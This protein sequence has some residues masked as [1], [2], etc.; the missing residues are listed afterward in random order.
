MA[1][2][3]CDIIIDEF[4]QIAAEGPRE[5]DFN[6]TREYLLKEWDNSLELNGSWM[7]YISTLTMYGTDY[8][9]DYRNE[10]TAMSRE[11]VRDL[12][13]KI[14]A[15]GNMVKVVMRPEAAKAE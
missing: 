7:N 8:L 5:D 11:K 1:D 2:E 6:K 12:A 15:D 13:R 3:L 4:E 10:L 9:A 14:L